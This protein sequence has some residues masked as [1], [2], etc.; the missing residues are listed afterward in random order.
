DLPDGAI[1]EVPAGDADVQSPAGHAPASGR[2]GRSLRRQHRAAVGAAGM[3]ARARRPGWAVLW[4]AACL[5]PAARGPAPDRPSPDR[6]HALIDGLRAEKVEARRDAAARLQLADR[7]VQREALPALIDRLQKEKDGQ[8]RLAVLDTVA[9]LGRD[10]E[11]A[12]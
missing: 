6:A 4:L 11:P 9:S 12:V 8:V 1:P 10:A 3:T 5:G 2:P 7:G